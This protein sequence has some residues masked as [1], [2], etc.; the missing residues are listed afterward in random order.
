[1]HY[2]IVSKI[3]YF[4]GGFV[5]LLSFSYL[6]TSSDLSAD[7]LV[8]DKAISSKGQDIH[9]M[10]Y[11]HKDKSTVLSGLALVKERR[12]ISLGSGHTSQ[13]LENVSPFLI[14]HSL[15]I[16]LINAVDGTSIFEQSYY[17]SYISWDDL[18]ENSFGKEVYFR[19]SFSCASKIKKEDPPY[20]VGR[21]LN[22][23]FT[24]KGTSFEEALVEKDGIIS[25]VNSQDL[26]YVSSSES[27]DILAHII[28]AFYSPS[29][30]NNILLELS[31][32]TPGISWSA[33]YIGEVNENDSLL[34]ITG[35]V[36]LLNQTNISYNDAHISLSSSDPLEV[37][38][39]K[40]TTYFLPNLVSLN[41]ELSKQVLLFQVDNLPIKLSYRY[42]IAKEFFTQESASYPTQENIE[43]WAHVPHPKQFSE[44]LPEGELRLYKRMQNENLEFLG[45]TLIAE[46]AEKEGV[47]LRLGSSKE[48][49]VLQEQTDFKMLRPHLLESGYVYTFSNT[50]EHPITLDVVAPFPGEW[51]VLRENKSHEITT[52]S[53]PLWK[54]KIAAKSKEELRYRVR[55]SLSTEL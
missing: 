44:Q 41:K 32:L 52:T 51:Q 49:T 19:N 39:R 1:M 22:F 45:N 23:S 8:H 40:T 48:I 21:L 6:F 10:V 35:W 20:T 31:Y 3:R 4:F 26:A 28:V 9:L 54:I 50:T 33:H 15:F 14:P 13:T 37:S 12:L 18:R 2:K 38:G 17:T 25:R 30:Q 29:L 7:S 16:R 47:E 55:L 34:D 27:K 36:T 11:V 46:S 5:G 24:E 42:T 53:F 43:V